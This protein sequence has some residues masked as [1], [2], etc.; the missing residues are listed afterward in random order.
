MGE[1]MRQAYSPC[2]FIARSVSVRVLNEG[3]DVRSVL[4]RSHELLADLIN[5]MSLGVNHPAEHSIRR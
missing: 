5:G 3:I 2:A 4:L 1:H